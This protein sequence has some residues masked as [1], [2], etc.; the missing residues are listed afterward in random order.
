MNT[1]SSNELTKTPVLFRIPKA[2]ITAFDEIAKARCISRTALLRES[3]LE[4]TKKYKRTQ[5][6]ENA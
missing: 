3:V 2:E 4:T 5:R 6:R 1:E